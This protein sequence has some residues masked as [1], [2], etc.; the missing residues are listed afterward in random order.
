MKLPFLSWNFDRV[1]L[2][3]RKL[4]LL[5][6]ADAA[7]SQGYCKNNARTVLEESVEDILFG[8]IAGS[9]A[10]L[11]VGEPV[12]GM[13]VA[14]VAAAAHE[15]ANAARLFAVSRTTSWKK[16]SEFERK[17]LMARNRVVALM[18]FER[19]NALAVIA[20]TAFYGLVV[21]AAATLWSEGW[22]GF[23]F[24]AAY[25]LMHGSRLLYSATKLFGKLR[26]SRL[27]SSQSH[28]CA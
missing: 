15:A 16:A 12:K 10:G 22:S 23:L 2:K 24:G 19:Y 4:A 8:A 7:S 18:D 5:Y 28:T 6:A 13:A 11:A 9:L 27:T 20:S 17:K 14:A 21:G 25:G 3:Y 26:S 1:P